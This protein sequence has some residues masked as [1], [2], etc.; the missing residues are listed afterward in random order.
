M[1]IESSAQGGPKPGASARPAPQP[2]PAA[3]DPDR[4]HGT[5]QAG[6]AADASGHERGRR[7]VPQPRYRGLRGLRSQGNQGAQGHRDS[8]TQG[9][10]GLK[11]PRAQGSRAHRL[12][13]RPKPASAKQNRQ[14]SRSPEPRDRGPGRT[15]PA[16]TTSR[17]DGKTEN[18]GER[19]STTAAP[20]PRTASVGESMRA[21]TFHDRGTGDGEDEDI[22][23]R[24]DQ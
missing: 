8:K 18:R 16:E 1:T 2:T 21:G 12:K 24:P 5:P 3:R 22:W 9:L 19:S 10:K 17:G 23:R 15:R 7:A 4:A 6:T 13:H 11:T 14:A 20:P